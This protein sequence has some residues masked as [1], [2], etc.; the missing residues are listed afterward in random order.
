MGTCLISCTPPLAPSPTGRK[1]SARSVAPVE[2]RSGGGH[3]CCPRPLAPQRGEVSFLLALSSRP[4]VLAVS[5]SGSGR[6]RSEE[7]RG[8]GRVLAPSCGDIR[9]QL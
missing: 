9:K 7:R 8:Q 2:T 6:P 4:A 1:T 3:G 5:G